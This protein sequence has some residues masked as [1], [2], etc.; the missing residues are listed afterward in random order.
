MKKLLILIYL[1][2]P[3]GVSAAS[4]NIVCDKAKVEEGATVVCSVIAKDTKVSGASGTVTVT[5]GSVES[6]TKVSK[7]EIGSVSA[8]GFECIDTEKDGSLT[9][10]SYTVK[11]GL[12]GKMTFKVSSALVVGTDFDTINVS[13]ASVTVD[14]IEKS[15]NISIVDKTPKDDTNTKTENPKKDNT[16]KVIAPQ[17]D[18]EVEETKEEE[19]E[20]KEV[21]EEKV[22]CPTCEKCAPSN[23]KFFQIYA[24]SVSI[25]FII[26]MIFTLIKIRK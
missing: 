25:L 15:N 11:V 17:N 8:T 9:I 16:P 14:I 26:Y 18:E 3:I 1:L 21:S 12:S 13:D 7:C 22:I 4:V 5:G 24:Y 23:E 6:V 19:E 2:F 20:V 10:A